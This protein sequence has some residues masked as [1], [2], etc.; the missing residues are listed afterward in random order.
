MLK[1]NTWVVQ[2]SKPAFD[3]ALSAL[4]VSAQSSSTWAF[5]RFH[6]S[7]SALKEAVLVAFHKAQTSV[8][9]AAAGAPQLTVGALGPAAARFQAAAHARFVQ[10]RRELELHC[11]H[12][13]GISLSTTA[14]SSLMVATMTLILL[15]PLRLCFGGRGS[16]RGRTRTPPSRVVLG[17]SAVRSMSPPPEAARRRARARS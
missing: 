10:L 4:R 6:V 9:L 13:F 16:R 17:S 8:K 5:D 15:L 14:A 7:G 1:V 2:Q 3:K 12:R 11:L